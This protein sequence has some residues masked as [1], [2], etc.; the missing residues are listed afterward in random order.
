MKELCGLFGALGFSGVE[1]FI[2]SG[3]VIF[4]SRATNTKTLEKGIEAHLEKSLGYEVKT[5]VRTEAEVCAIAAYKPFTASQMKSM[6]A[7]NVAFLAESLSAANARLLRTLQTDI[8]DIHVNGREVYWIC[9][10]KQSESKFSNALFE[11]TLKTR[12]T[13][14]GINTIARLAA[15]LG[16]TF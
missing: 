1:S 6:G 15:K 7:C 5:F 10:K 4:T 16:E 2:A 12:A 8:D 3:N 13:F 11:K 9:K 14:R